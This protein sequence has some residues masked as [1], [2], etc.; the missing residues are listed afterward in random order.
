VATSLDR[1]ARFFGAPPARVLTTVFSR[2]EQLVGP[3]IAAHASP[4]SLRNGT[5]V[6]VADQPAWAAQ[7]RFM[8][9]DLVRRIQ[10]EVEATEVRRIEI[11]TGWPGL[12]E[13][14]L[15]RAR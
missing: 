15:R 1:V 4:K 7:L 6:V 11:R 8:A 14:R 10:A 2:W 9:T 5:L 13:G 3:E 12:A